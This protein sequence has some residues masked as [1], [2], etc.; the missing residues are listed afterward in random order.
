MCKTPN[1]A[2]KE[3]RYTIAFKLCT[4]LH[5]SRNVL[6]KINTNFTYWGTCLKCNELGHF[7]KEYKNTPS[8]TKQFDNTMHEQT[9]MNTF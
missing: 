7:A 6:N 4:A 3:I 2:Y 9:M 5:N 1:N 8:N